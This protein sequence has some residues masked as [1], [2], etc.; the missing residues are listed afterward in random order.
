M[1]FEDW[2]MYANATLRGFRVDII[3]ES[4]YYYR[5]TKSS[6]VGMYYKLNSAVDP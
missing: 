1:G 3:P 5:F 4:V 6:M 2:E